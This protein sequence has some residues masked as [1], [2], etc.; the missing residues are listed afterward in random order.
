[1]EKQPEARRLC[2]MKQR[3]QK[4]GALVTW[5]WVLEMRKQPEARRLGDTKGIECI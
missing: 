3:K 1:M 4:K 2:G 5:T